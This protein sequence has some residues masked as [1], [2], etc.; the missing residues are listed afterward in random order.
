[1]NEHGKR[2]MELMEGKFL[3]STL[4]DPTNA[5]AMQMSMY[6]NGY[7]DCIKFFRSTAVEHKKRILSHERN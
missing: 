3:Y 6:W 5:Q 2:L 7:T 4:V 1:M